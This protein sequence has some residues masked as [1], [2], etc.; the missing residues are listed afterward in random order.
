VLNPVPEP[1]HWAML[2]VGLAFVAGVTR[3]RPL[4]SRLC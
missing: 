1:A 4:N 2:G 3:W